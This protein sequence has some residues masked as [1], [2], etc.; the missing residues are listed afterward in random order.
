MTIEQPSTAWRDYELIDSG[1]FSKLERFGPYVT[2]RP[3]PKALWPKALSDEE[4]R[5][6]SYVLQKADDGARYIG[7][8]KSSYYVKTNAEV[9]GVG[10]V[11]A[12]MFVILGSDY[13]NII[14][15]FFLL[16]AGISALFRK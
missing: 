10:F 13:I 12:T 15:A 5:R 1:D 2:I 9:A 14:S 16:I 8:Y 7:P 11:I 4:W 3:E 6:L